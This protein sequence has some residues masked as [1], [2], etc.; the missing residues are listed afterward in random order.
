[1]AP[2]LSEQYFSAASFGSSVG[3]AIFPYRGAINLNIHFHS[4]IFDG[5][6]YEDSDGRIGFRRL[7]VPNDSEVARV[8]TGIVKKVRRL[9]ERRG[10]GLQANFEEADPLLRDQ[11]LLAELYS[12]SV[13]GRVAVGSGTGERLKAVRFEYE[14]E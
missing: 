3:L 5:V 11:P 2:F 6:Y 13:Q 9:L 8:T 7:P 10:L 4:L 14:E 1:M 12:A